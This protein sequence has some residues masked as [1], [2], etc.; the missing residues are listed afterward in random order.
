[1][2]LRVMSF[3]LLLALLT[4]LIAGCVQPA[5]MA[6]A[7][8]AAP[9][10]GD[11]AGSDAAAAAP[12]T[13][14]PGGTW[15]RVAQADA[16]ILNPILWSD[17]ASAAVSGMLF[18]GLIGQDHVTGEFTPDGSM[19]E[20]WT[21]SADGLTWTFKLRDGITW[22][23]GDPV[24]AADFKFTY[25]AIASDLV[26]TVRKSLVE[27]IESITV[28]D[29]LTV[30]VKFKEVR[31]DAITNVGLGWLPSHLY[32]ADFSDI[33]TSPLNDE[34]A[35]SAGPFTF[36][37]WTRD[38]NTILVR[39]E[40]YWEGAPNM[41]GMIYRIVPDAGARLAQLQSGE[42]DTVGIEPAQLTAV[43]GNPDIT[44]YRFEDDGYDYIA[45][46]QANPENPQP[47][48]DEN[49]NLLPQDPHPIL[50]DQIV[51]QAM[52]HALDYTSI[53]DN[54]YL[55]Q[56]YQIAANVLPAV[57]WAY[58]DT[59]APYDYNPDLARQ[60]LE[61]AGWMD[62]NNDGIREKDGKT[63]SL[64]LLTNAGNKTREDLGVLVQDQ[65]NAI[66]F[67]IAF[68][69]IDFGTMVD[70][71]LGQTYDMVII[72][73]TGLGADPN[74]DAF[75]KSD[76]DTPGSGFNFVS[77]QSARMDELLA[78]GVTVPGCAPEDRAP[79][80]KEIQSI[81]HDQVPYIFLSGGVG[82][83]GYRNNWGNV[84]PG[85][86]SFYWNV[87]EWYNKALQP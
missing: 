8:S 39:N 22:S 60:M 75:W 12:G 42:V 47:G 10:A 53:I 78:Q 15:T 38:D 35:V 14:Q 79:I 49:G 58:D 86:W 43:Q 28:L 34:P 5:P 74:D 1:M 21:V 16:S 19:S 87:H 29:P 32:A 6:P 44:V 80:Y 17:N 83:T 68:E 77:F 63:L 70:R 30:A 85:P 18:P 24:D 73:W 45:L 11:A 23:D 57:S 72:G 25:D 69:A 51:R 82:N 66:G 33:M 9:A 76:Y 61:S 62:S 48:K 50:G 64:T 40:T 54:V 31:C 36:Q 71:M 67:D 59:L 55:G 41:D 4:G 37:S 81:V 13:I 52:A 26:E 20:S 46:N 7:E 27:P 56:G 3:L 65:L 84:D 2:N